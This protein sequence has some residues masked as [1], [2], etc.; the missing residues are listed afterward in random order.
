LNFLEAIL[1]GIIQGLT[2]FLPI[3]STGHLTITG[4][5]LDLITTGEYHKWTAFIAV[6]QIGTL[7]AILFYF[8]NDL[9]KIA[10]SFIQDNFIKPKK[11]TEQEEDSRLG[12]LIVIGSL[13][14]FTIG[15]LFDDIIAENISNASLLRAGQLVENFFLTIDSLRTIPQI[16]SDYISV[17]QTSYIPTWFFYFAGVILAFGLIQHARN[18]YLSEKGS[19]NP[20][21]SF[22]LTL[23]HYVMWFTPLLCTIGAMF[24]FS[25]LVH[26]RIL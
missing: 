13:P 25:A 17:G 21:K 1:L 19:D 8:K 9:L 23:F 15:L 14:V 26:I 20:Q 10:K 4:K 3:S 6:I 18:S 24:L 5:L 11:I 2:E 12:W 16:S 7:I 22:K